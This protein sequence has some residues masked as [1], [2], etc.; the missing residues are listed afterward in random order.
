MGFILTLVYIGIAYLAPATIFGS[1]AQFRIELV[2]AIA[3]ILFSLPSLVRSPLFRSPQTLALVGLSAAVFLSLATT[4]WIGGATNALLEFLPN[5]VAYVLVLVNC[6]TKK[7][8]QALILVLLGVSLFVIARGFYDLRHGNFDS[9][10]LISQS[11]A[12]GVPL[13]RLRG[14]ASISDPND[15]SQLLVSLIPLLF[16]FW[17]KKHAFRNFAL[18]IVPACVLIFGMYLSHSRGGIIALLAVVIIAGWKRIGIVPSAVAAGVI[19]AATTVLNWTGGRDIS[20]E[21]GAGRMEAWA[22]GLQ[23]LRS[24]PIFG[25]GYQRFTE[26][27][28]ITAHNSIVVCAAELGFFG[29]LFWVLLV[30][31][32]VRSAYSVASTTCE[33]ALPAPDAHSVLP[34]RRREELTRE[35]VNHLGR[36]ITLSLAGFLVA[37][38]FLSRAYVMTLFIYAGM[39]EVILQL[40]IDRGMVPKRISLSRLLPIVGVTAVCLILLVYVMLRV[41]NLFH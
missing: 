13:Y 40:A 25:V 31:P 3:A 41:N 14:A 10:Y 16:I 15:L 7:H 29:L 8:L 32:T 18:V 26:F 21:A 33:P 6:R 5:A 23:L 27:F 37:G 24:H 1:G 11:G 38:W 9:A 2:V 34:L 28:E 20:V 19:F 22:V 12:E 36:L 4:G 35:Q 39:A 30:L 17:Q